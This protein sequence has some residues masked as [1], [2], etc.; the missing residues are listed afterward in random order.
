MPAEISLASAALDHITN[1]GGFMVKLD[2]RALMVA[3]ARTEE[4]GKDV[5]A[6]YRTFVESSSS[7][8][9]GDD[10]LDRHGTAVLIWG[11]APP[12]ETK[13]TAEDCLHT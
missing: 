10:F 12:D 3:Y 13:S 8:A 5:E 7:R 1:G 2:G 6:S 4:D 11:K 9:H